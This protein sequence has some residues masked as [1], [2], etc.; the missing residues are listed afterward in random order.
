MRSRPWLAAA[1]MM[2]AVLACLTI[3]Q[4]V[5]TVSLQRRVES[6]DSRLGNA[7]RRA[8][9]S[10]NESIR[11][12][13]D[14]IDV[15]LAWLDSLELRR[16]AVCHADDVG[17]TPVTAG[18]IRV[19]S[20]RCDGS[21]AHVESAARE[22]ARSDPQAVVFDGTTRDAVVFVETL[23]ARGSF[24]MVVVTPS[25]DARELAT[26]I[27]PSARTWLAAEQRTES[28]SSDSNA[29]RI[30]ILTARGTIVR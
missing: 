20:R 6:D 2:L 23:R 1:A 13:R 10:G 17:D 19:A 16:V 4:A 21:S 9:P 27:R 11:S 12:K 3:L 28:G 14:E 8:R 24:A 29:V 30:G 26:T 18:M 25:V 5:G 22:I 7:H 15:A